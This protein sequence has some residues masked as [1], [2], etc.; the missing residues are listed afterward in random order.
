LKRG[1]NPLGLMRVYLQFTGDGSDAVHTLN[2]VKIC[3]LYKKSHPRCDIRCLPSL[4]GWVST[5]EIR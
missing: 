3:T 2:I 1:L 4:K 5:N